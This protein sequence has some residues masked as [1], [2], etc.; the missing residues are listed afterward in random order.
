VELLPLLLLPL[1]ELLVVVETGEKVGA[2]VV[3]L[4][5]GSAVGAVGLVVGEGVGDPGVNVGAG[6]GMAVGEVC[7]TVGKIEGREV[8]FTVGE[9]SGVHELIVFSVTNAVLEKHELS[10]QVMRG[11]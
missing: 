10:A 11:L 7:D 4:A 5:V 9:E 8:G 2:A 1:P 6:V 3:G